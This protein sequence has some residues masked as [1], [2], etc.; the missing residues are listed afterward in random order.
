MEIYQR[1]DVMKIRNFLAYG[2]RQNTSEYTVYGVGYGH[3][4][5]FE[6]FI[7]AHII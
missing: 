4:L 6:C 2:L 5:W 1:K 3:Y 7:W